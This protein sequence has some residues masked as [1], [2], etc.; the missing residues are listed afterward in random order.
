MR[1]FKR[2]RGV[3]GMAQK[4]PLTLVL[5]DVLYLNGE[6][7]IKLRRRRLFCK[8]RWLRDTKA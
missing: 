8:R 7:L 5:F 3:T 6:S 4:I 2:I 1:R